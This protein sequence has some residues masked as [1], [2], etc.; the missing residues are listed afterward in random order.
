MLNLLWEFCLQFWS[1]GSSWLAKHSRCSSRDWATCPI[2]SFGPAVWA[3]WNTCCC[4]CFLN[5]CKSAQSS[6]SELSKR[7]SPDPLAAY[8]TSF[9]GSCKDVRSRAS[10]FEVP[11]WNT[12]IVSWSFLC[13]AAI[14]RKSFANGETEDATAHEDFTRCNL[15]E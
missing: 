15:A 9:A 14:T 8:L 6:V 12:Q 2:R 11:V 13:T 1:C 4:I 7:A 5:I 10:A 3:F